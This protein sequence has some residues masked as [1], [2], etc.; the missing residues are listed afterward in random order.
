MSD[1]G[2]KPLGSKDFQR[3]REALGLLRPSCVEMAWRRAAMEKTPCWEALTTC[4]ERT[5]TCNST[6]PQFC[7]KQESFV[8]HT[9]DF[10]ETIT[11]LHRR[12]KGSESCNRRCEV[13]QCKKYSPVEG[14]RIS[15]VI[16]NCDHGTL[17]SQRSLAKHS[18]YPL[19]VP[20]S[21]T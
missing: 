2:T 15:D 11:H 10:V 14:G 18:T 19:H 21:Q 3:H 13:W 8:I 20:T 17:E 7:S 9:F 16:G 6:D 12:I 1:I 4:R 5:Q